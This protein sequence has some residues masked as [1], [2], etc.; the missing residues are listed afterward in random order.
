M[1]ESGHDCKPVAFARAIRTIAASYP[2]SRPPVIGVTRDAGSKPADPQSDLY[3][4]SVRNAGGEPL[5]LYYQDDLSQ[6]PAVLDQLDGILFSGG[7]D[8]DPALYGQSWHPM[9]KAVHPT[10][11]K[12]ELALIAAAEARRMPILGI[13]LGCQ[14]INVHRGGSLIQFLPDVPRIDALEHRKVN[15]VLR[16]HDVTIDPDSLLARTIGKLTVNVNTYHKQSVD[17]PGR[18]L[19]ITA[20]AADGVVE[21]IEDASM[22]LLVGVQWHPERI[23]DEP[24]H[25]AI[26]EMLV[27]AAAGAK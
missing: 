23:S 7:D 9:A 8:L 26:F 14:L 19:R 3:S 25:R 11:Q 17:R 15:G 22:P 1:Q 2:M 24:E 4:A 27:R 16:R 12:W 5:P 13:C 21:G 18:G 20:R 10:R 6:I